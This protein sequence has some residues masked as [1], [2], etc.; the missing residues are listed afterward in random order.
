MVTATGSRGEQPTWQM[1]RA[2]RRYADLSQR[3]LAEMAG[4]SPTAVERARG[5][6]RRPHIL[7]AA[8]S[9]AVA[10]LR[11]D[12]ELAA[13]QR[14]GHG[15]SIDRAEAGG[16]AAT[17]AGVTIRPTSMSVVQADRVTG[18]A[19]GRYERQWLTYPGNSPL[20]S[21]PTTRSTGARGR[22][23]ATSAAHDLGQHNGAMP[24]MSPA[25]DLDDVPGARRGPARHP[26]HPPAARRRRDAGRAST[27][28]SPPTG[29]GTFLLESAEHGRVWSRYSFVGARSH[30]TLDR[31]R[32]GRRTGWGAAGRRP[33]R[34]R[35]ARRRC[36]PPS[37]RCTPSALARPAAADRRAG[38]L[39]SA[40]TPSAGSS[41]CPSTHRRRPARARAGDDAGHR[42]R[43]P[44]PRR[45]LGAAH[46]QRHQLRRHRRAGRL[47]LR[48]RRRPAGPDDRRAGR[49][50]RRPPWLRYDPAASPSYE[51][52]HRPATT[53]ARGRA[54]EG[55]D[56]GRRG[57]PGR[58]QP[59]VRD[60]APPP[61][62]STSTGCCG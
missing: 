26:G 30:A 39:S 42:P 20:G 18:G 23:D 16:P 25:P 2:A 37:R 13:V 28:S 22:G 19:T 61:T 53:T 40:T 41:G 57:V 17:G 38:R 24:S 1:L 44:R 35:P 15:W 55:G 32:R 27:A 59:A 60:A 47:G 54:G 58:R 9:P 6:R 48:R 12:A 29:P 8:R 34:R 56:P 36:A 62:R 5:S 45:R 7:G 46:R 10:Q 50:R 33:D 4:T 52:G 31:A 11:R 49:S 21:V 3:E 51:R 14:P 43:R